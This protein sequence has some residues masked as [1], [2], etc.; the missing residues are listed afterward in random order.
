VT[1]STN[2]LPVVLGQISAGSVLIA[3]SSSSADY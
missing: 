1:A 2:C 3:L